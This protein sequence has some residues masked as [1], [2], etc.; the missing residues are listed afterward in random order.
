MCRGFPKPMRKI[1]EYKRHAEECRML[2]RQT[3]VEKHRQMLLEMAATWEMLAESR[4]NTLAKK[5]Q[6][7]E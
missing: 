7:E 5:D 4:A 1:S 3:T 2:A 6:S